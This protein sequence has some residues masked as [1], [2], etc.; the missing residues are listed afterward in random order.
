MP[1]WQPRASSLFFTDLLYV[2]GGEVMNAPKSVSAPFVVVP[3]SGV[4]V[5]PMT[6]CYDEL[7]LFRN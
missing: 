6:G 2:R 3:S 1:N 7:L 4:K 5:D